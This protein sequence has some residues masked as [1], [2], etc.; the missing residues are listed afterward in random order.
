MRQCRRRHPANDQTF[1][2]FPNGLGCA[3]LVSLGHGKQR[4]G[5]DRAP[6]GTYAE[7]PSGMR[8][9]R[10]AVMNAAGRADDSIRQ[11]ALRDILH[12][13]RLET[14]GEDEFGIDNDIGLDP[15]D[16]QLGQAPVA[17]GELHACAAVR[18]LALQRHL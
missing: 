3:V 14:S 11:L 1:S 9:R 4:E 15:A 5:A 7:T 17:A 12:L 13:R 16:T 10:L 6:P 18:R 8:Q 2:K